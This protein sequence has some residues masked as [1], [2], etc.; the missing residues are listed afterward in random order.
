MPESV[1]FEHL[2]V[3]ILDYCWWEQKSR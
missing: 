3:D 2:A 1:I